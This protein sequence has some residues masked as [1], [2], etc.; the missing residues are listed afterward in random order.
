MRAVCAVVEPIAPLHGHS[1]V[2][3]KALLGEFPYMWVAA[4]PGVDRMHFLDE[5]TNAVHQN[6]ARAEW[7]K[8]IINDPD[9]LPVAR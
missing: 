5:L 9:L 8:A 3:V 2:E 6:V 7:A 4:T 1:F